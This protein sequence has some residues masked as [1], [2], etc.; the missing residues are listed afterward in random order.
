MLLILLHA[1]VPFIRGRMGASTPEMLDDSI[2]SYM[3]VGT[4][5]TLMLMRV[6]SCFEG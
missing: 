3:R 2:V 5:V 1:G 4:M 6:I